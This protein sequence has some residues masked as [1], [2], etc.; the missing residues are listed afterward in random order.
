MRRCRHR[1]ISGWQASDS[2]P[3]V[4]SLHCARDARNLA[5]PGQYE[6]FL[7]IAERLRD[8]QRF[9]IILIGRTGG[10]TVLADFLRDGLGGEALHAAGCFSVTESAAL[11]LALQLAD[12]LDTGNVA[13]SRGGGVPCV[14]VQSANSFPGHWDPLGDHHT[15]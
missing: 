8:L 6:N 13:P 11:L 10:A 4:H 12:R 1:W 5:I 2:F 15:R 3:T 9:E 14:V 7:D